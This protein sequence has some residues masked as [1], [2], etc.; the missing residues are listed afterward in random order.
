MSLPPVLPA[1]VGVK[2]DLDNNSGDVKSR[3]ATR[4]QARLFG[5]RRKNGFRQSW[6][7]LHVFKFSSSTGSWIEK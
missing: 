2:M 5:V 3:E 6:Q 1:F 4:V 7:A